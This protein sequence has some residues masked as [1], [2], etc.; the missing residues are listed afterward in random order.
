MIMIVAPITAID[1]WEGYEYQ[2]HVALYVALKNINDLL[3]DNKSI[4]G[5]ELQI[6]GEEDFSIRKDKK[7][8]SLHQVKHGAVKLDE[9]DKFSFVIEILQNCADY[10]YF[11][12]TRGKSIPSN[13]VDATLKHIQKLLKEFDKDILV[14]NELGDKSEDDYI[15]IEKIKRNTEK[16][17]SY[18]ILNFV[19]SGKRDRDSIEAA[20]KSIKEELVFYMNQIKECIDKHKTNNI[21]HVYLDTYNYSF[22]NIVEVRNASYK[23]IGDILKFVHPDWNFIDKDYF[24]FVYNQIFI[25][26]KE[27]ITHFHIEKKENGKCVMA[28]KELLDATTNNYHLTFDSIKYQYFK[29]LNSIKEMYEQYPQKAWNN[30]EVNICSECEDK[31]K[32]NLFQQ[33]ELLNKKTVEEKEEIIHN[34]ILMTPEPGKSNNLPDDDLISRLLLQMLDEIK[35]LK[36]ETNNSIQAS[37]NNEEFYRLSLDNSS[38]VDDLQGRLLNELR[39]TSDKSLIFECD[40]LITNHLNKSSFLYDGSNISVLGDEQLK[41][42]SGITNHTINKMKKDCHRPKVIRL[43]DRKQAKGELK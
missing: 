40:V 20:I 32:C 6:E 23:V 39:K 3:R 18:N 26:M 30:C 43:I 34:L 9:N 14:Q 28:Y 17:S 25:M 16:A 7:Y 36:I 35:S 27:R 24:A 2:G 4:I 13:F 41:E 38:E 10:G 42:L 21:D 22:D 31:E 29:V 19:C 15:I 33:I 11:H 1:S 8:I 5:M 12:I 37:K